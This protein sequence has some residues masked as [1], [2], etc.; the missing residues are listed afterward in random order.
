[1]SA[2]ELKELKKKIKKRIDNADERA[3]RMVFAMLEAD[4]DTEHS[5]YHLSPEQEAILDKRLERDK[6]GLT[7]YSTW[8][9]VEKRIKQKA[10]KH[11]V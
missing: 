1:M 3:A 9:E 10:K 2:A 6:K 5:N 4:T 8:E 7:K 11:G